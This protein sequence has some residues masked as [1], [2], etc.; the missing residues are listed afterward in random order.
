MQMHTEYYI[1]KSAWYTILLMLTP[2]LTMII[3]H[4][5]P[6]ISALFLLFFICLSIYIEP[7]AD[8]QKQPTI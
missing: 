6:Y 5:H 2:M 1:G 3:F 4:K 8:S 7:L